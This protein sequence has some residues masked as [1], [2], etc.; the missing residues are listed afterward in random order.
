MFV[1]VN[2]VSGVQILDV[3]QAPAAA[4]NRFILDYPHLEVQHVAQATLEAHNTYGVER[5]DCVACQ[6][7][8]PMIHAFEA[9]S[10]TAREIRSGR[11]RFL[12]DA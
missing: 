7:G 12:K 9:E 6:G 2:V 11:I 10:Q 5:L 8:E 1:L 4:L 3:S